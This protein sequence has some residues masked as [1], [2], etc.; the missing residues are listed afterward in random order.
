MK[1]HCTAFF[2][3]ALGLFLTVLLA[4][5]FGLPSPAMAGEGASLL[6]RGMV[7]LS[8][9]DGLAGVYQYAFPI[10]KSR[11]QTG[12]VGIIATKLDAANNDYM[13]VEQI[14]A[15][16]TAGWEVASHGYTHKRPTDIPKF[17]SDEKI[18]GWR[19][20]NR[21]EHT[22]QTTYEYAQIACILEN[23]QPLKE[24][25]SFEEMIEIPGSFFYDREIEE[26][27]VKPRASKVKASELDI[28]ACS[29]E[30]ELDF[31]KKALTKIGFQV[32]SYITP[33]NFWNS[34][35]KELSRKYYQQVATG[36]G[37][38]NTLA[39][40][41]PRFISRNVIHEQDTV[42]SVTR[43]LR[44]QALEKREWVVLCMHDIGE[45]VGWEPWAAERFERLSEWIA[46]NGLTTVTLTQ[47]AQILKTARE[48]A[49]GNP[50]Q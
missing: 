16:A 28:R 36:W 13:T 48:A 25:G 23:G 43:L 34:E 12:V 33:Y 39:T 31:S 8:F 17:Y 7:T 40:F 38:P 29:Y 26:L 14:G 42:G 49:A 9:D 5:P 24:T 35:M 32:T 3:N 15:L 20:D 6:E 4:G 46:A 27:H 41:D 1:R 45:S 47:G 22:F 18:N 10:L 50:P 2:R 19:L 11:N 30:R 37:A 44:T 21:Q